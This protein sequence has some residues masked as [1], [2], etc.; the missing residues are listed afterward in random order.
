MELDLDPSSATPLY[1][2]IVDQVRRLVGVGALRPGDR[3]P[4]VRELAART[5][6]NRNTAARA[7]QELEATGIVR[8]RVGQG[9]FVSEA[10]PR[11]DAATRD[12]ALDAA[13]DRVLVEA[14]LLGVPQEELGWRLSRRIEI[15][16]K[17]GEAPM[18]TGPDD[19]GPME[20]R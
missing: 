5:R 20:G 10:A 16:R 2:Q 17:R 15:F 13:L 6:I 14:R 18:S 1:Q 9:T 7:V 11:I 3:L 4:T 8:T 19:P 12:G